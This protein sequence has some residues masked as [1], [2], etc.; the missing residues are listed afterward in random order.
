MIL[1][2]EHDFL[3]CKSNKKYFYYI[4]KIEAFNNKIDIAMILFSKHNYYKLFSKSKWI[5]VFCKNE[6]G[7]FYSDNLPKHW[8]NVTSEKDLKFCNKQLNI[9]NKMKVFQ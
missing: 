6:N 1:L 4:S 7:N 9:Y 3:V 8:E 2:K 5:G